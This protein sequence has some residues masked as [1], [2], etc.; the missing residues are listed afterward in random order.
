MKTQALVTNNY[1]NLRMAILVVDDDPAFNNLIC[2]FLKRQG[3]E[4]LSAYS[5]GKALQEVAL[6]EPQLVI[7]DYQLPDQDGLFLLGQLKAIYPNLPVILIT[8]Y[9]DVRLA[10]NSM[11]L[12]A[13]EFV[14]KPVIPDE[15]LKVVQ[16]ALQPDKVS[17]KTQ[18]T[19]HTASYVV[20]ESP[21]MQKLWEHLKLV[22]PTRMHVL[23]LGES[24]T[25]KEHLARQ[26]HALSHRKNAPFVAVDCGALSP[27]L[28]ASTLFGHVK[29]AFTGA[30]HDKQGVLQASSGGT[31]FL[32]EL[33]NLPND[34]QAMLLR[35]VQEG[36][37][38]SVGSTKEISVDLRIIAA[39]NENLKGNQTDGTFR[40]DLFHRLNEFSLHV[41]PLRERL[42]DLSTY[43]NYFI[44][45]AAD[46]LGKTAPLLTE[47]LLQKLRLYG[48]PGNLR[49]LRNLMRRAVLLS[50]SD[51]LD[52][53]VLPADFGHQNIPGNERNAAD[54]FDLKL[55]AQE[56][57]RQLIVEALQ[58]FRYNKSKAAKALN[59][60]RSTLYAKM[61]AYQIEA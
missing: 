31:L 52:E 59:I 32:D 30:L 26:I 60:D 20:G 21:I 23:I 45:E 61:K 50:P 34:V 8:S 18:A 15:L 24:G 33:G 38:S 2:N 42:E 51:K 43:C 14:T 11:K 55:T 53:G 39:T 47:G 17:H 46:E 28:A 49:E 5:T 3:F 48:W 19:A 44:A 13:L 58:T 10:V 22:A 9:A 27:E 40:I 16:A 7:S 57:E 25:G 35:A 4:T 56:K 6:A 29:G 1:L 37:I 41:P 12:G 54:A 36:T